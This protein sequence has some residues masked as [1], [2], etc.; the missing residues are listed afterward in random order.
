MQALRRQRVSRPTSINSLA[1]PLSR[2]IPS[3]LGNLANLQE[4]ELRDNQFSGCVP[5]EIVGL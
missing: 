5:R 2:P 1:I 4:L 3:E